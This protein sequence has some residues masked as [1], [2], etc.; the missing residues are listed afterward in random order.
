MTTSKSRKRK[1][2]ID[3]VVSVNVEHQSQLQKFF[4]RNISAGGIFLEVPGD[5]PA[6]GTKLKLSFEVPELGRSIQ[7]EAEVVHH[8]RFS[9]IDGQMKSVRR[10]GIGL[11]FVNLERKDEELIHEYVSGK[12][13]SVHA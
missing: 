9:D 4:S 6:I 13:L 3:L 1:A 12:E 7:A 11:K 8:H 5:P 2:R 10:F